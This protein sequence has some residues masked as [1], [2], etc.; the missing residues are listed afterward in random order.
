MG[1]TPDEESTIKKRMAAE[2]NPVTQEPIFNFASGMSLL[3]FYALA[4]QCISTLAIVKKETNGWKWPLIQ[5]TVM[6]ALA[7]FTAL[8]VFQILK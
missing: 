8:I 2:R 1:D 6:S 3:L 4:M 7:Y 5:L